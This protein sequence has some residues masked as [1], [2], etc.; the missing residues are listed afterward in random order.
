MCTPAQYSA[1]LARDTKLLDQAN[2]ANKQYML[3]LGLQSI[4]LYS[5]I[6]FEQLPQFCLLQLSDKEPVFSTL[7]YVALLWNA[8]SK[9]H[10]NICRAKRRD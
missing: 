7:P 4:H 9:T 6:K 10:D 1:D 8:A 5:Q 3:A 2:P